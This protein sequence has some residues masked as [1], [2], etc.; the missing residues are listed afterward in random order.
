M[1]TENHTVTERPPVI[2]VMGHIDHGKSTL[3]DFIRKTNI[4]DKEA[5]GITQHLSAYEVAHKGKDGIEHTITF[6]D[7]P[8]HEAFKAIRTR[9]AKVADIGILVVSAEDGV[10]P[11]TV[12]A[13]KVFRND[14]IPFVVAINK[15]D[16][17]GANIER[18]KQNLAEADVFVEGYGGEIPWAA[19]SAKKGDG[20]PELLDLLLLVSEMEELKADKSAQGEGIIIESNLDAK[21]GITATGIIKNG[22]LRKGEFAVCGDSISPLRI[23]E[24]FRGK[25][26]DSATFSSPVRIIG[27]DHPLLVGSEFKCFADKKSATEYAQNHKLEK[28]AEQNKKDDPSKAI[29]P[30]VIKADTSGS[31]DALTYEIG[32]LSNDRI[33]PKIVLSG[34]GQISENDIRAA[35]SNDNALI[36]GFHTK[37]EPQAESLA[38]RMGTTIHSF[39]II[40]KLT[41]WLQE[42]LKERTPKIESEEIKGRAKVL[43]CFSKV[44]D[45]QILGG[46]VETGS[47]S[48]NEAVKIFR[49]DVEIGQGR[50]RELQMQ[51]DKT[52]NVEEGKEFGSMIESKT[53]IAAGDKIESY[54]IVN[55]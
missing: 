21:K 44:K 46:K 6:L 19:I 14:N 22:T 28:T 48:V 36:V 31:L 54:T 52:S 11:Q 27:W 32:K 20:I 16:K 26:I 29:I 9:G 18:T 45:K 34:I 12:E 38:L 47:I 7:T 8:G 51:K 3:L 50:I 25:A 2:A 4:V 23:V 43:K 55:K 17:E 5:G 42:E 24:D 40:Y 15:I 1:N 10:K 33:E 41:E 13:I 37:V 39:D 35:G 53:E 30:I 49:R